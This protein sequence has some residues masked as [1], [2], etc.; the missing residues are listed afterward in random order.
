MSVAARAL[1]AMG[2]GFRDQ[3]GPLLEPMVGALVGDVEPAEALV[4]GPDGWALAFD[5][6]RTPAPGWL[7]QLAGVP[8][9]AGNAAAQRAAVRA[10]GYTRG[11][12]AAIQA[13]AQAT[14]TES[15]TVDILEREGGAYRLTV[16]TYMRETPDPAATAAAIR[17]ALPAG[18]ATTIVVLSGWLWEDVANAGPASWQR[19]LDTYATWDDVL[20]AV[21]DRTGVQTWAGA[22]HTTWAGTYAR[23]WAKLRKPS[24]PN[25]ETTT[26]DSWSRVADPGTWN[27]ASAGTWSDLQ[28]R[29]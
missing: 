13:A 7:G 12:P 24:A 11:T 2:E 27:D 5:L 6:D 16:R 4:A 22:R 1:D 20:H 21:P 28:N 3:A 29:E 17:A 9:A 26:T 19:L 15:R 18:L 10:R 14:L 8:D 25:P 23:T